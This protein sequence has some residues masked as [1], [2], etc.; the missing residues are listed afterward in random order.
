MLPPVPPLPLSP[1]MRL[2]AA[3]AA[4]AALAACVPLPSDKA[5]DAVED[6]A[7]DDSGDPLLI[8]SACPAFS[9]LVVE[10]ATWTY[11]ATADY[12]ANYGVTGSKERELSSFVELDDGGGGLGGAKEARVTVRFVEDELISGNPSHVEGAAIYRC[13]ADG[14]WL[15][16]VEQ[17]NTYSWDGRDYESRTRQVYDGYLWLPAT[18]AEGVPFERRWSQDNYVDGELTS[19]TEHDETWEVGGPYSV[20]LPGGD[21]STWRLTE[22]LNTVHLADD[23]GLVTDLRYELT[24]WTTP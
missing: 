1:V 18:L 21:F 14:V 20:S 11:S 12:T 7:S 19:T 4:L 15:E 22:G 13:D 9:G 16:Q 6:T 2:P 8:G 24:A 5:T 23:V 3:F 10:G 17:D